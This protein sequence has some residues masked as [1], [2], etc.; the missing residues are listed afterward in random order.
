[1]SKDSPQ[2]TEMAI[3]TLERLTLTYSALE[4]RLQLGASSNQGETLQ[5]W[6][7][8]RFCTILAP[9]LFEWLEKSK[10]AQGTEEVPCEEILM[11]QQASAQL[12]QAPTAAIEII[13]DCPT[14]LVSTVDI[15]QEAEHLM[16]IFP[17][18]E[19]RKAVVAFTATNLSQWLAII[20]MRFQEA[21]WPL[22]CWPVWFKNSQHKP[23]ERQQLDL[24]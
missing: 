11:F 8:Q 13:A 24:H 21:N 7:T 16:L 20:Y 2:T 18:S 15:K 19:N 4:D 5:F 23:V 17:V 1:M 3:V 22:A 14:K 9:K 12:Q 10:H 6:L